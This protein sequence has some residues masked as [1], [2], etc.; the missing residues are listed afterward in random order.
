MKRQW[1]LGSEVKRKELTGGAMLYDASRAG[2]LAP[3]WFDPQYWKD[4]NELDGE[5]RGRGTVHFVR[6]GSAA[7]VL[8]HYRR[9]GLMSR[10]SKDRYFWRGEPMTRSFSEWQLTYHL[11]R[12]GLPVPA[13]VAARYRHDGLTYTA[14]LITERI[15]NSEPL[16]ERLRARSLSIVGWIAIGRCIR[17]FHNLGVCHADLNAHNILLTGD[18]AVFLIDFDRGRLMKPGLWCDSNLVRLRRSLEKVT[19]ALPPDRISEADWHGLLDGY[20]EIAG[21]PETAT[22]RPLPP[23]SD[24]PT[25]T[26]APPPGRS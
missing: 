11:H 24:A 8:R 17:S 3:A 7:M 19:Y 1:P 26:L 18:G 15:L 20:R 16:A 25:F 14:D 2:N 21:R 4:R 22:P 9:G 12:A 13:P 6:H 10:V 23:A 5:A